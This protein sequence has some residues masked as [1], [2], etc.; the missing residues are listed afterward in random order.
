[1]GIYGIRA[2]N[3]LKRNYPEFW[4]QLTQSPAE[5]AAD[6]LQNWQE[7]LVYAHKLKLFPE[8]AAKSFVAFTQLQLQVA[9]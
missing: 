8:D 2:A 4:C 9:V 3:S 7:F 5:H 1:M 6:L